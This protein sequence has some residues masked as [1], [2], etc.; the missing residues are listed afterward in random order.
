[1]EYCDLGSLDSAISDGRFSDMVRPN[2]AL[3]CLREFHLLPVIS[4]LNY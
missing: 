1:M 2:A 3:Q 4:L